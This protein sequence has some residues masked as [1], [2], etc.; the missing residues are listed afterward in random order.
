MRVY[1][2]LGSNLGKRTQNIAAAVAGLERVLKEMVVSRNYETEPWGPN[3]EQPTFVN[4]C[5]GGETQLSAENLQRE[6][7]RL[8]QQ[9]GRGVTEKW[10]PHVIDIDLIFYGDAEVWV[11]EKV[12]PPLGLEERLFVLEP[13]AEIAPDVRHPVTGETVMEM[14]CAK[15]RLSDPSVATM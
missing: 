15:L 11:G 5:V 12:F 14:L 10:G 2:S 8:E 4:A 3:Q 1:F 9:I 6:I 13:L 7:K